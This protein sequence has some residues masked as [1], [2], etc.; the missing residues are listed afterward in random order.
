[1]I[2]YLDD[3]YAVKDI[4]LQN[5]VILSPTDT[6]WGLGCDAFSTLAIDKIRRIKQRDDDKPFILLLDSIEHLKKY[7]DSIH[8]RIETLLE[9]HERPLSVVYKASANLPE[10]LSTEEGTVAIRVTKEP[11]LKDLIELLGRPLVSTSANVQ[12]HVTPT[13]YDSVEEIVK[14]QV[15][16]IFKSGRSNKEN[17][18]ASMLIAFSE[19]GELIFLRK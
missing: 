18:L 8:P 16:Y 9:F 17:G 14:E 6:V 12:A 3:L 15:D 19:E 10:H 13:D 5:K 11:I 7:V 4:L 2:N 1:M